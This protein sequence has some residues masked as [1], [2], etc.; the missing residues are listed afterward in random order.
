M[1]VIEW[2][3]S[4]WPADTIREKYEGLF[5]QFLVARDELGPIRAIVFNPLWA[6][7]AMSGSDFELDRDVAV[8]SSRLGRQR[9]HGFEIH[10]GDW[11]P[12]HEVH[13]VCERGEARI[14]ILN[15][16]M[17]NEIRLG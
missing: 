13:V 15:E 5:N 3:S 7:V 14:K 9:W 12:Q 16:E 4:T 1:K 10:Q 2:D 6:Q 17:V 11:L 8:G